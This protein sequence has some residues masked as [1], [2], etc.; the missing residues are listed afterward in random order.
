M[1]AL[2][3]QLVSFQ[4]GTKTVKT[5]KKTTFEAF[6]DALEESKN[7]KFGSKEKFGWTVLKAAGGFACGAAVLAATGGVPVIGVAV[8]H[9]GVAA[10]VAL[11]AGAVKG[12]SV[13]LY[14]TMHAVAGHTGTTVIGGFQNMA[15]G[16]NFDADL[17]A[18]GFAAGCVLGSLVQAPGVDLGWEEAIGMDGKEVAGEIGKTGGE[19]MLDFFEDGVEEQM[20]DTYGLR[21]E[22]PGTHVEGEAKARSKSDAGSGSTQGTPFYRKRAGTDLYAYAHWAHQNGITVKLEKNEKLVNRVNAMLA[23]NK[24]GPIEERPPTFGQSIY[25]QTQDYVKAFREGHLDDAAEDDS[26]KYKTIDKA[27]RALFKE[28]KENSDPVTSLAHMEGDRDRLVHISLAETA[29]AYFAALNHE[30]LLAF[31]NKKPGERYPACTKEVPSEVPICSCQKE[32]HSKGPVT[33]PLIGYHIDICFYTQICLRY[34]GTDFA[35]ECVVPKNGMNPSYAILLAQSMP[36]KATCVV[37]KSATPAPVSPGSEAQK[38]LV[39][40]TMCDRC[41]EDGNPWKMPDPSYPCVAL[42]GVGNCRQNICEV[43]QTWKQFWESQKKKAEVKAEVEEE[44]EVSEGKSD[45][46]II[47]AFFLSITMAVL[48]IGFML[49]SHYSQEREDKIP[50]LV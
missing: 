5:E 18:S 37:Y 14:S 17:S 1:K 28:A 6:K 3:A 7:E 31:K 11:T 45:S 26:K 23:A 38:H 42:D 25:I 27:M 33:K 32:K 49:F 10:H 15:E 34:D 39:V 9:A 22:D 46:K 8:A 20:Q 21:M 13:G 12:V 24:Q 43:K 41:S 16:K 40:G 35:P 19:L 44:V 50:L 48:F 30:D 36:D 2:G 4:T 47:Y 29:A